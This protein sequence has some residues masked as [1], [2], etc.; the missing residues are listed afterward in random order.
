MNPIHVYYWGDLHYK[1]SLGPKRAQRLSALGDAFNLGIKASMHNDPPVT[2]VNPLLNMWIS[3]KRHSVFN[4]V[5]GEEQALNVEQAL[6]TYTINAAYQFGL[7]KDLGSLSVG[8]FIDYV[9][10]DRNPLK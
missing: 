2:P 3:I 1:K 7:E 4:R 5:L 10:L 8:K 6:A 9:V